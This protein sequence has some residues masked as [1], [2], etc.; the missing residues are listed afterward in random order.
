MFIEEVKQNKVNEDDDE[1]STSKLLNKI[2]Q[3]NNK[4]KEPSRTVKS[5]SRVTADKTKQKQ[6]KIINNSRNA[7]NQK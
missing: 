3:I 1:L 7:D 4:S 6:S 2:E 5:A